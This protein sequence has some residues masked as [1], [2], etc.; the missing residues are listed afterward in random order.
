MYRRVILGLLLCVFTISAFAQGSGGS[1]DEQAVWKLEHQYWAYVQAF[2]L[3]GY[4]TL[5]HPDFLGWPSM[6][7]EPVGKAN[8]TGW[9]AD[10]EKKGL[11][12]DSFAI[13]PTGTRTNSTGIVVFYVIT[14]QWV[15]KNGQ[16]EPSI[17][18]ITHTWVRSGTTWQIVSGM[19][20]AISK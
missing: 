18:R 8:I 16:G 9:I 20:A 14:A 11:R 4:R 10:Y 6:S 15:G 17:S 19:S 1:V 13:R 2:D 12:L 5:W 7:P 3:D